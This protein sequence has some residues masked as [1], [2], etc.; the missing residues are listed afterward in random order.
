[1]SAPFTYTA[2]AQGHIR[3]L[4]VKRVCTEAVYEL[5]NALLDEHLRFRAISYTWGSATLTQSITCNG[6]N[7][8][9]T[10]SV[11]ELLSSAVIS[12][13]CDEWPIWVDAICINQRDDAEKADQVRKMGSVYSLADEVIVWLGPASSDSD[14]AMDTI[15]VVS[16]KKAL[17][18][19]GNFLQFSR[20]EETIRET[21][22]ANTGEE[23][24]Y[25][26]GS[27]FCRGWFQRLWVFQEVVLARKCQILCGTNIITWDDFADATIAIARL[28]LHQFSIIFP[29]VVSGLRGVNGIHDM[30]NT[31]EIRRLNKQE[32]RS[33]FLLDIAQRRAVTDPRDRVYGMLA[34]ASSDL[35]E[36]IE[37]DYSQQ[38]P[39]AALRLYVDCGKACIEEDTSLALLYMLSGR[40]KHP[41]L[42]SWCPDLDAPQS[43]SFFLHPG[44]KAGIKTTAQGEGQPGAW[45]EPGCD[46]LYAP[47]CRVDTVSQVV[48]STYCWSSDDRDVEVPSA[49]DAARNLI[50]EGECLALSRQTSQQ[51]AEV[52]VSYL[53]T[54][55][56]G[57]LSPYENDPQIIREA[58]RRNLSLWRAAEK[59]TPNEDINQR[60]RSATHHFHGRIGHNCKGRKFFCTSGGRIGVG[61]P[62]TQVGDNVYI[63]YG[64]GPLYL[65]RF[66]DTA[67]E[68]LGNVYIHELMNLDETPEDVK[69]ENEIIVIN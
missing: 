52:P 29:N 48:E 63:L 25:A 39:S 12:S 55:C 54:L 18:S 33:A 65:L 69:E 40:D 13:L 20:S 56:E 59:S 22:L 67:I 17:I 60:V 53:L 5:H 4:Q 61:P 10:N 35:R 64:A 46:D 50:W 34:V 6:Q 15:R 57:F 36:K 2:L 11:F 43:R 8:L 37:V 51:Q 1:M 31:A 41:D 28:Q 32:F 58:Y 27:F 24:R 23:I 16:E 44:W 62:E 19:Q 66:T 7:L 45:F 68:V 9:V 42:P 3:V 47:G 14:L 21:G 30:K 49:E 38:G 26:L